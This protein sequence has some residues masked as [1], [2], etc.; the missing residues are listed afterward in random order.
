MGMIIFD[1]FDSP[2][3]KMVLC[4][5][6]TYLTAVT[7][8][9]QKYE[10][11]HIPVAAVSGS[12]PVLEETKI[13]L[14]QYFSG[15]IP[16]HLPPMRT[17][18][19]PFQEAIWKLLLEIPY[20]QTTTYGALAKKCAEAMGRETMSAQAVGGAVGRN[21]ISVLIPCHRVLGAD[22]SLTGYAGGKEKKEALLKR[23]NAIG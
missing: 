18:G 13:W 20:G 3:G 16:R 7:F 17:A 11:K 6:G 22:G 19:T 8:A 1:T 4:S 5:D 9:G 15:S 12:C 21:P 23:E 10:D 14:H 2:L